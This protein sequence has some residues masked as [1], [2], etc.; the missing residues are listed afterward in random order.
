MT[1]CCNGFDCDKK[2][3][4]WRYIVCIV[5]GCNGTLYHRGKDCEHFI[6]YRAILSEMEK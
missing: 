1:L 2:E 3:Y 6:D 5:H 4:C